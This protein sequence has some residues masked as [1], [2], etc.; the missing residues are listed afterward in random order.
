MKKKFAVI[1]AAACLML[2]FTACAKDASTSQSQAS[3]TPEVSSAPIASSEES[4]LPSPSSE[5]TSIQPPA[6]VAT[7]ELGDKLADPIL[8]SLNGVVYSF[9][10][11]TLSEFEAA[12]WVI[13]PGAD[14]ATLA[15]N[16]TTRVEFTNGEST[17][18]L[19]IANTGESPAPYNE[20]ECWVLVLSE[21]DM[22]GMA[23]AFP[24][25]ITFGAT[26]DD[27]AAAYGEPADFYDNSQGERL[28]V[29]Y[30]FDNCR[31]KFQFFEGGLNGVDIRS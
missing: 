17:I 6:P 19:S 2:A 29:E 28:S 15:A 30:K 12:G 7:G 4:S 11:A 14:G 21:R 1:L 27:I 20:C 26:P 25:G 24:G 22:K 16:T 3:S 18:D 31:V 8:V 5:A 10:G 9:P 13:D 23:V